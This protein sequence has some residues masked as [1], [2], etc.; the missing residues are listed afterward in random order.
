MNTFNGL[1]FAR[2]TKCKKQES[3]KVRVMSDNLF[4]LMDQMESVGISGLM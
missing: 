4:I 3:E 1:S 2:V